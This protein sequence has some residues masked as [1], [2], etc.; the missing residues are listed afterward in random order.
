M[1]AYGAVKILVTGMSGLI[2]AAL[3]RRLGATYELRALNRRAVP[4]V[5]CHRA[6][7]GDLDAI[8]PAFEGIEVVVHLA[9]VVGPSPSFDAI[10]STNVIG[11][12]NVFEAARRAGVR[13]VVYASSGAVV[14]GYER[15]DPYRALVEGR[16]GDVDTWP[17]LTHESPVRPSG[18]YGVSKVWG[19]TL[20]RHYADAH[21]LSMLG[22]R[23]GH[24]VAEDRPLTVR[25]FTV[26]CSQRD[27]VRMLDL[28]IRAPET[29]RCEVFFALSD[30]RW[31]YRDL[32]HPCAV[33]G[34]EP[35]DRAEDHRVS[36]R[37]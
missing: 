32:E 26:W 20:A 8:Q 19:E 28:S 1:V 36:L 37:A 25:D 3:G 16:Y 24:V 9:A 6:D 14:A 29:V 35:L 15:E 21:G 2:G 18:L 34:Y 22:I 30:D 10:L 12:R 31:S 7:I 5:P 23:I 33:L 27:I 4:G 11:T 17:R 13:R